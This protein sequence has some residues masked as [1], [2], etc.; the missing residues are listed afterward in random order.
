ME[1]VSKTERPMVAVEPEQAYSAKLHPPKIKPFNINL[2]DTDGI[3]Y[4]QL[5]HYEMFRKHMY[6]YGGSFFIFIWHIIS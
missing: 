6:D 3:T 5:T 2:K 1:E 4:I